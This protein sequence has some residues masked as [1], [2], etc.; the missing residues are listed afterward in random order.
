MSDFSEFEREIIGDILSEEEL[1]EL[2]AIKDPNPVPAEST[3]D[4][5][6]VSDEEAYVPAP[7]KITQATSE[8]LSALVKD[9]TDAYPDIVDVSP[10]AHWSLPLIAILQTIDYTPRRGMIFDG[11]HFKGLDR[12]GH[13][14]YVN[15]HISNL[16]LKDIRENVDIWIKEHPIMPSRKVEIM[17]TEGG[18]LAYQA[19]QVQIEKSESA[20]QE[21]WASW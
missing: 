13:I 2:A 12:V 20:T 3:F 14:G 8:E 17:E 18:G 15:G 16:A 7:V 6:V 10:S 9:I 21:G 1:E 11:K 19:T 4:A 5:P